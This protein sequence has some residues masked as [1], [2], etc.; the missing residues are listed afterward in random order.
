MAIKIL[1][2]ID[3]PIGLKLT[4]L[5]ASVKDGYRVTPRT[6]A[7]GVKSFEITTYVYYFVDRTKRAVFE[8]PIR[9]TSTQAELTDVYSLLYA[10]LKSR[11]P[12]NVDV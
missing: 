7:Q 8:E 3:T 2:A 10:N 12:Q 4:N 1:S 11:Y 5:I 9:V 6:N